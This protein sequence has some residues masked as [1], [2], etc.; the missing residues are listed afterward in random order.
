MV[1]PGA[2]GD[3]DSSRM[4]HSPASHCPHTALHTASTTLQTTLNPVE[5]LSPGRPTNVW[6]LGT[7][8]PYHG[9]CKACMR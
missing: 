3:A 8:T 2:R 5:G 9:C 1:T 7:L 6:G 4:V